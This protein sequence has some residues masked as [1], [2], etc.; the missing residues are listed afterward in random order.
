MLARSTLSDRLPRWLREQL[1][2][3]KTIAL[4]SLAMIAI[5]HGIAAQDR[6][7]LNLYYI[8]IVG[9]AYVLIKRRALVLAVLVIFVAS[10]TTLAQI[11]LS[12]A[13]GNKDPL[14][15]PAVNIVS[16]SVLLFLA[17]QLGTEAYRF[18]ME[19]QRTRIQQVISKKAVEIRAIALQRTSHEV[20]QPLSAILAITETL[21]DG[22][23]G[24][25]NALQGEFVEDI[26]DCARHL[27]SL[28]NDILDYAKAEAGMVKLAPEAIALPELVNQCMTIVDP[29]AEE[30]NVTLT[31][32]VES[33]A[34][35]IAADPLRVK[36]IFLNL[37][38]NAVKFNEPGG[39]VKLHV[40]N[41]REFVVISVRDTGR[42]IEPDQL[43]NLFDPYYQAAYG[44]QGIGTGLG[45][46]I[47]KQLVEL[48]GGSIQVESVVGAGSVFHVRLPRAPATV[49]ENA[50]VSAESAWAGLKENRLCPVNR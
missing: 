15:D 40:R 44:D 4:L 7:L 25:I 18:Q 29:A 43:N 50:A 32:H 2:A 22:S 5:F 16:L 26:D 47:T 19:E 30:K 41:E 35:E 13:S 31:G 28:I 45:L 39:H 23:I 36:Q 9:A 12:A 34:D 38:T 6:L 27:M 33:D 42:G 20:R 10:G 8:G 11:Y 37:L 48:H 24:E 46:S 21:L 49:A 1:T 14:M 17:W 3:D